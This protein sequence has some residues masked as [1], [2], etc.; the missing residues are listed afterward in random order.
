MSKKP[1]DSNGDGGGDIVSLALR[2][3]IQPEDSAPDPAEITR[4]LG[5]EP[6]DVI[7]AGDDPTGDGDPWACHLWML[8]FDGEPGDTLVDLSA[9]LVRAVKVSDLDAWRAAIG[10][11]ADPYLWIGVFRLGE[12]T[13]SELPLPLIELAARLGLRIHLSTMPD[14]PLDEWVDDDN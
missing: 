10:K 13:R 12:E 3:E 2:V 6:T 4:L 8:A 14:E 7:R 1:K 11:H 5:A 9:Q